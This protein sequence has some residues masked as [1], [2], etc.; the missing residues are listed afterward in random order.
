[1]DLRVVVAVSK[2]NLVRP[3]N[4]FILL[5]IDRCTLPTYLVAGLLKN[6]DMVNPMHDLE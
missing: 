2:R 3:R 4:K 6:G 5:N 1:M